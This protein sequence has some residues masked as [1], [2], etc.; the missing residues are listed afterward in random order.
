VHNVSMRAQRDREEQTILIG[1]AL[2]MFALLMT[3]EVLGLLLTHAL[4]GVS[5]NDTMIGWA[6]LIAGTLAT[7]NLIRSEKG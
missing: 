4:L 5:I 2:G 6:F 3:A 1:T 7:V